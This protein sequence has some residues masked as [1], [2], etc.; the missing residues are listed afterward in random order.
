[1]SRR[2]S[3]SHGKKTKTISRNKTIHLTGKLAGDGQ[4]WKKNKE[5]DNEMGVQ[6]NQIGSIR[7]YGW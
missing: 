6:N 3:R 4:R 5:K 2:E 7:N 1:M